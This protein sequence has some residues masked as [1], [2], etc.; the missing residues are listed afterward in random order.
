[1]LRGAVLR[2]ACDYPRGNAENPVTTHELERKFSALVAGRFG[3]DVPRSALAALQS[4][5]RCMDMA[6][7]FRSFGLVKAASSYAAV[8]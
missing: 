5:D 3:D 4:I 1:M 7:L 2:A 8:V 6:D